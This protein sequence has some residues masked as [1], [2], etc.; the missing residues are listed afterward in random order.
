MRKFVIPCSKFL[1]LSLI[2]VKNTDFD[3]LA[4][5]FNLNCFYHWYYHF[6]IRICTPF[7]WVSHF[8]FCQSSPGFRVAWK[9]ET[10]NFLLMLTLWRLFTSFLIC[11]EIACRLD[12]RKG[13]LVFMNVLLIFHFCLIRSWILNGIIEFDLIVF[14]LWLL[15]ISMIGCEV[16]GCI[17]NYVDRIRIVK[18]DLVRNLVLKNS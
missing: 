13:L 2:L 9:Q 12:L 4:N 6:L 8:F 10:L 5:C 1:Y 15:W 7:T 14:C 17:F 11:L 3:Y 16:V 18:I